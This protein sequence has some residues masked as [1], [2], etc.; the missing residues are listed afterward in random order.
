[1]ERQLF[2]IPFVLLILKSP[3]V[4]ATEGCLVA[5]YPDLLVTQPLPGSTYANE[6]ALYPAANCWWTLVTYS[7]GCIGHGKGGVKGNYEMQC[8][9]DSYVPILVIFT[10][11]CALLKLTKPSF[12]PSV[13]IS[14]I[15]AV[16]NGQ[17]YLSDCI[18]SIRAQSYAN[19]EYIVID[20]GS[21]DGTLAIIEKNKDLISYF[22]SER[23]AG[24][25][26]ALNKGI[27]A[28]TGD[29]IGILN[30]DDVLADADV[31][32]QVATTFETENVD[33][34]YGNLNYVST[35]KRS[36]IRKWVSKPFERKDI[37][38]G[39]MPAHPTLYLRKKLFERFGNYSLNFGTAADYELML[40]MLYKH[41][42]HAVHLNKRLVDMRIGGM[43]NA[44][45]AHRYAAFVNDYRA[46]RANGIP[47][48]MRTL[49]FKKLS[50]LPQFFA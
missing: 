32:E 6:G 34:V 47:F 35:D 39:W 12:M 8:P 15:T 24:M 40:R 9:I 5:G 17:Q 10:I 37:V 33:G 19:L 30:A 25:Y 16:Y 50:K 11:G 44:S 3:L 42:I 36:I 21:T 28:A 26:D 1:M 48:A 45:L 31:L 22:A 18:S 43:S 7:S 13:K 46:I 20:G 29:V 2:I 27:A 49:L 41:Q 38:N 23:D 14:L 4:F